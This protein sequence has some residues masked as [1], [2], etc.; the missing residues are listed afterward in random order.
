MVTPNLGTKFLTMGKIYTMTAKPA[1]GQLF[2]GWSGSYYWPSAK[3]SF[4]MAPNLTL[5]ANFVPN[6]FIRVAGIYSG[7]FYQDDAVR[8]GQSGSF[9]I[10]VTTRGTY[11]GRV[12]VGA[13][14]YSI[15]GQ[16]NLQCLA[17]NVIFRKD[18]T[19]LTLSLRVGTNNAELNQIFGSIVNAGWTAAMQGNRTVF[20]AK[21]NPAIQYAGN[22]TMQFPGQSGNPSL[23]AGS[24]F[25]TI[26]VDVTGNARFAGMLA[27]GTKISQ[28][29]PIGK[30]GQWPFYVSLYSGNGAA[31]SWLTFSNQAN[32]DITG[33]L[34]WIKAPS[35]SAH[36][37]AGGFTN[38]VNVVGSTYVAPVPGYN[39]LNL[40][41]GQVHFSGGNLSADFVNQV[42]LGLN[43]KVANLSANNLSMSFSLPTGTYKGTVTDPSSGLTF[44]FCGAILQKMNAGFGYLLGA[45]QSSQVTFGP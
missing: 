38:Q 40:T 11:T 13:G 18:A 43:S 10:S 14:R 6:P 17:T 33:A 37:Y 36:Y 29:A 25:G 28:S 27:D 34:D 21:T 20:N 42:S 24:G 26:R 35:S 15:S 12:Q 41:S 19:M 23:P 3:L 5:Q 2:N 9:S 8:L 45:D 22:Y 31:L 30:D 32:S 7:L 16:L 4:Y 39:I 1:A 44:P